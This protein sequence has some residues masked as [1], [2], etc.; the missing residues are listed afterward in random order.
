MVP[1][2]GKYVEFCFGETLSMKAL[3]VP[4]RGE[5]NCENA[6]KEIIKRMIVV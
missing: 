6:L 3:F 1:F 4:D 5:L 2:A